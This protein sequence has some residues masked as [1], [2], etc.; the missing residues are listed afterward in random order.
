LDPY[1]AVQDDFLPY[2]SIKI[3]GLQ[4]GALELSTGTMGIRI[5]TNQDIFDN[6][7]IF[8]VEKEDGSEIFNSYFNNSRLNNMLNGKCTAKDETQSK[9]EVENEISN[10]RTVITGQ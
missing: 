3:I 9:I 8:Y 6:R 1:F 7:P 2:Y 10:Y 5:T 4:C